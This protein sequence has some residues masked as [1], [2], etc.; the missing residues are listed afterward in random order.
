VGEFSHNGKKGEL[1]DILII[2]YQIAEAGVNLPGYNYVINYHIPAYPSALE[3]RFGRIDRMGKKDGD[4]TQYEQIHMVYLLSEHGWD[5]NK[6]NF[7]NA[8]ITYES[9][10]ASEIPTKNVIFTKKIVSEYIESAELL[11]KRYEAIEKQC[12]DSDKLEEVLR[13][14]KKQYEDSDGLEEVLEETEDE[15]I[16]FCKDYEIISDEESDLDKIRKAILKK[17][18]ELRKELNGVKELRLKKEKGLSLETILGEIEDK[19]YYF[20]EEGLQTLYAIGNE[21]ENDKKSGCAQKISELEN[22]KKFVEYFY[23]DIR[24]SLIL[25]EARKTYTQKVEDYFEEQFLFTKK[26]RHGKK[27]YVGKFENIFTSDYRKLLRNELFNN[28]EESEK[29]LVDIFLKHCTTEW[30]RQ[31]PFFKMC[32]TFKDNLKE[33]INMNPLDIRELWELHFRGRNILEDAYEGLVYDE[34]YGIIYQSWNEDEGKYEDSVTEKYQTVEARDE[35]IRELEEDDKKKIIDKNR[36]YWFSHD[37]LE[38]KKILPYLKRDELGFNIFLLEDEK[39]SAIPECGNWLKLAFYCIENS[40]LMEDVIKY[41]EYLKEIKQQYEV[42]NEKSIQEEIIKSIRDCRKKIE[43]SYNE[44]DI[45]YGIFFEKRKRPNKSN[46]FVAREAYKKNIS[47]LWGIACDKYLKECDDWWSYCI[48]CMLLYESLNDYNKPL[49]DTKRLDNIGYYICG[50]S[51]YHEI[52]DRLET[53]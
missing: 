17:L 25:L 52:K 41:T 2:T 33:I 39:G 44:T 51:L 23:E 7:Y 40:E 42:M 49:G 15:F 50:E 5:T 14:I 38:L 1:P 11:E 10:V 24:E 29:K 31:L 53:A 19:I 20:N 6:L 4:G 28:V 26:D 36:S 18:Q 13:V 48:S 27:Y 12:E 45:F 30:I 47:S 9:E 16:E 3:Q 43:K 8:V 32:D 46:K 21:E 37:F 35:R 22:Y 34:E